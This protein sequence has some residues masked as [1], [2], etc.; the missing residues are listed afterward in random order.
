[1]FQVWPSIKGNFW[2]N[3]FVPLDITCVLRYIYSLGG[4]ITHV[5]KFDK[6]PWL[7]PRC[8]EYFMNHVVTNN[9]YEDILMKTFSYSMHGKIAWD[10][11]SNF[12]LS[13]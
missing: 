4:Y 7:A 6:T 12:I 11:Y 8:L 5:P 13:R 10:W 2:E 3:V 9:V 1:M